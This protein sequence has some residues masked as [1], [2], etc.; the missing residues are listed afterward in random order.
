MG[1]EQVL[2]GRHHVVAHLGRHLELDRSVPVPVPIQ[3]NRLQKKKQHLRQINR[4]QRPNI[5]RVPNVAHL[6]K[7]KK[8]A[9]IRHENL[10]TPGNSVKLGNPFGKID[11][12]WRRIFVASASPFPSPLL[13]HHCR[14]I[15]ME[16]AL[17]GVGPSGKLGK[18]KPGNMKINNKIRNSET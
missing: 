9:A 6:K 7:K 16:E 11:N 14:P 8:R 5:N 3:E 4:N 18:E 1:A 17:A 15:G 10:A 2:A 12:K 13:V